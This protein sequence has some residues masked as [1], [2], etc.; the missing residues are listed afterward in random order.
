MSNDEKRTTMPQ[1]TRRPSWVMLVWWVFST[2]A[3]IMALVVGGAALGLMSGGGY[4]GGIL[5]GSLLGGGSYNPGSRI[6]E[7][8]IGG[9]LGGALGGAF[10]G[11]ITGLGQWVVVRRWARWPRLP[12]RWAG[13]TTAAFALAGALT[14]GGYVGG[15]LGRAVGGANPTFNPDR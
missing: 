13:A 15:A 12:F 8:Y 7:G 2:V 14:A 11:L 3:G 9:M 4:V 1:E 5:G 6:A 10:G